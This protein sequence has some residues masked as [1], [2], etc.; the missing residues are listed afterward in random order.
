[1]NSLAAMIFDVDGT[2]ADTER[3]H[4]LAFNQAFA[5]AG[6]DW[7]W[8]VPVYKDLL[9]VTGGKERIRYYIDQTQP[10]FTYPGDADAFIAGLHAEK[11]RVYKAIAGQG[12]LPLRPGVARLFR[13]A[14][15]AGVRLAIAT[16]TTPA[17]VTALLQHTL[18]ADAL[19][20][21]EVIG[22]GDIVERKKPAPD[23][24]LYVL[25][26]LGLDASA[27]IAFEDSAGGLRAAL[28]A[29][30]TTIVTVNE[31][32]HHHPFEGA[33]LVLNQLGEP[34]QPF[35]VL[36]GDAGGSTFL[37]LALVRR[38]HERLSAPVG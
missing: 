19:E 8:S 34:D 16:T 2:L 29:D 7:H 14:R 30:L 17:N 24:Y 10:G 15:E 35:T 25:E 1:M 4:L 21:F 31:F 20:W 3:A 23:I 9:A 5:S 22:A 36:S 18:G 6:L 32:T 13:E 33:A 37:D 28:D 11:T 12:K 38:V 26:R 27:C